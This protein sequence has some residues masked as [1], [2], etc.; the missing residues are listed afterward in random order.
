MG[1]SCKPSPWVQ[2]KAAGAEGALHKPG[3]KGWGKTNVISQLFIPS[4]KRPSIQPRGKR[5]SLPRLLAHMLQVPSGP[6][7]SPGSW[8]HPPSSSLL[9]GRGWGHRSCLLPVRPGA[10]PGHLWS[11]RVTVTGWGAR[12]GMGW[13]K[14]LLLH[15]RDP[16]IPPQGGPPGAPQLQA[17][18]R[19]PQTGQDLAGSREQMGKL[20]PGEEGGRAQGAPQPRELALDP[21][22]GIGAGLALLVPSSLPHPPCPHPGPCQ[23]RE[24]ADRRS[25]CDRQGRPQWA[26]VES[27]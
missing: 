18:P 25:R 11:S 10:E 20:R 4:T 6:P 2:V 21:G 16:P 7:A 23:G 1:G 27:G 13:M 3:S 19:P 9:R 26:G 5:G 15:I 17:A 8:S 12:R 14:A 22:M 24:G